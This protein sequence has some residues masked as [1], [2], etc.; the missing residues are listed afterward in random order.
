MRQWWT[1]RPFA[2]LQWLRRQTAVAAVAE[3]AEASAW[4]A[5]PERPPPS[6][7][8]NWDAG[9]G[10]RAPGECLR[11]RCRWG[12]RCRR[13]PWVPDQSSSTS[14]VSGRTG[15]RSF[16]RDST[17]AAA[18]ELAVRGPAR[19]PCQQ[20]RSVRCWMRARAAARISSTDW[21]VP[22]GRRR[23]RESRF[24]GLGA[25]APFPGVGAGGRRHRRRRRRRKLFGTSLRIG[26]GIG[27]LQR[28]DG[29]LEGQAVRLQQAR[30]GALAVP[31]DGRQHDRAIDLAAARL[32]GG[33][34]RRVQ[35]A[36]QFGVGRGSAP[37]S[38]RISS[39]SRPR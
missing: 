2:R 24:A 36:Q 29:L 15:D 13:F 21:P 28:A 27:L 19:P 8:S 12:W 18:Q 23:A 31:H 22:S 14:G 1:R 35:D 30:R 32:L 3:A 4:R 39:S 26:F 37:F 7:E 17:V 25:S 5:D 20:W 11:R 6:A 38:A 10:I 16:F 33:L 34:H 9:P